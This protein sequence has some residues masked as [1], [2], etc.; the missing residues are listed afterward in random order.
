M[1]FISMARL[2]PEIRAGLDTL[3]IGQVSELL[4]NAVGFNIFKLLDRHPERPY[5]LEE[6]RAELPEAVGDIQ[7]RD[8]YDVWVK[9]LRAKSQIEY[10]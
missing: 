6:I 10:R 4:P 2:Q 3:E 8:K 9:S 1:G 5:T 7:S